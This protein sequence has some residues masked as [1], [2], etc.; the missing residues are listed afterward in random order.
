MAERRPP[1]EQKATS[2]DYSPAAELLRANP[3]RHLIN[4]LQK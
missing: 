2:L 4:S 1:H 3:R